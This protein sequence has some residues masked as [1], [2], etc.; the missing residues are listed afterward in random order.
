M[1]KTIL[2]VSAIAMFALWG[3]VVTE[4]RPSSEV[5]RI[6]F[7]GPDFKTQVGYM[8]LPCNGGKIVRGKQSRW[9]Y[10][11]KAA[12]DPYGPK[13]VEECMVCDAGFVNCIRMTCPPD[14]AIE[15]QYDPKTHAYGK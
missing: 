6:Y 9:R 1:K 11:T 8:L 10:E 4:A 3:A 15:E 5:E 2:S 13:P 7:S 12:C 14:F